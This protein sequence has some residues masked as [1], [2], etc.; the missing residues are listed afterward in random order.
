MYKSRTITDANF[1]EV[2]S[3]NKVV[4]IDFWAEWCG[5]CRMLSPVMDEIAAESDNRFV[6]GKLN[7]DE[8]S[9]SYVKYG[10]R[11]IPMIVIFKDGTEVERIIGNQ[12]KNH[13]VNKIEN[14][15]K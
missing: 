13:I 12:P 1:D 7:I 15:L 6:V 9:I 4:V 3:G 2:I 11:S 8:N 10:V 5:P 14:H